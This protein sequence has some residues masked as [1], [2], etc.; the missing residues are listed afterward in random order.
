MCTKE[1]VC[2]N[3]EG[4]FFFFFFVMPGKMELGRADELK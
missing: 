1:N 2:K 4:L 3:I